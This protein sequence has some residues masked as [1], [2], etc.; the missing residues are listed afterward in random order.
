[1]VGCDHGLAQCARIAFHSVLLYICGVG[2][3]VLF[4]F[5]V[6]LTVSTERTGTHSDCLSTPHAL[7][8]WM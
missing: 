6:L 8:S 4:C 3:H 1:M 2:K 5:M 7:V